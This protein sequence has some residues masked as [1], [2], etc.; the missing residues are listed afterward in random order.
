MTS[1][2]IY[3]TTYDPQKSQTSIQTLIAICG[4]IGFGFGGVSFLD[5]GLL[6]DGRGNLF[7]IFRTSVHR[8]STHLVRSLP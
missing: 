1:W 7:S 3:L 2:R 6:D 4:S 5:F 8:E